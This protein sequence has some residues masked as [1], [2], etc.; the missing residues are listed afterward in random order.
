MLTLARESRGWTQ[1]ELARKARVEQGTVSKVESDTLDPSDDLIGQFADQLGYPTTFFERTDEAYPFGASSFYHRKRS[2]LPNKVLRQI[3]ARVNVTRMHV[4]QL[5]AVTDLDSRCLFRPLNPDEC[6]GPEEVAR[7]VRASWRIGEG[8]I[9]DLVKVVEQAGGVVVHFDFGTRLIDGLSE[10]IPP[11][12]PLFCLNSNVGIPG[13][14]QR[15]TLA[16]E[17]GHVF[18]HSLPQPDMEAQANRFASELLAPV[19]EI[20]PA[21]RSPLRLRTL[22]GLKPMWKISMASMIEKAYTEELISKNE[23][24]SLWAQMARYGY[25]RREPPSLDVPR[26]IPVLLNRLIESHLAG[27][28][29]SH[30]TLAESLTIL[31]PELHTLYGVQLGPQLVRVK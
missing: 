26:E 2:K 5:A 15:L 14:R 20:G 25:Q 17:V 4:S 10:W 16:H 28:G 1:T 18:M 24:K 12:P 11:A 7:L 13:D 29:Y 31:T 30:E 3:Q 19:G 21:L 8:P 23:R 27:L 9:G 22:A 6:G